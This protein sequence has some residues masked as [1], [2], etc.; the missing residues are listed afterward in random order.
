M[1]QL[2][3]RA[4]VENGL[5]RPLEP[6]DL[7][8]N[9]VVQVSVEPVEDQPREVVKLGGSLVPYLTG[10]MPDFEE[11]ESFLREE[12]QR[13]LDRLLRQVDGDFEERDDSSS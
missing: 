10:E 7:A 2:K 8:E 6:V 11:L 13:S 1:I 12:H 5:L 9:E 4:V 3:F